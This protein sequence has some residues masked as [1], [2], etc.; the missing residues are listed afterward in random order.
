MEDGDAGGSAPC[1]AHLLIDGTPV[2]PIRMRDVARF[3]AVERARLLEARRHLSVQQRSEETRSLAAKLETLVAPQKGM[4]IAVY[5]PI[6]GEPDLRDWMAKTHAAGATILL[7]VVAEK[8]APLSF[9][10]WQPGCAMARGVWNIPVPACG[11]EAVPDI[12]IS[13]LLGVDDACFRLGNGGGYYDRTLAQFD[14][15][16]KVIGVGFSNCLIPTIFPM[17]WDIP[18]DRVVLSD[19][20]VRDRL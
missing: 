16:P 19:G 4:R 11:A 18:M 8:N 15:L 17:P 9:R 13:P 1:M 6:R 7:P 14:P 10:A 12:V 20:P 5:W 2:D 3:R